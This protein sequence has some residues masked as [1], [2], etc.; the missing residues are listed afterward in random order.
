MDAIVEPGRITGRPTQEEAE[1]AVR[2]LIL[3]AGDDPDREGL[4]E[5]P[6]RVVRS[7][8]EFYAGYDQGCSWVIVSETRHFERV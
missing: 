5:T 4:I 1:E 3:W 7:Y 2:T 8:N 6:N